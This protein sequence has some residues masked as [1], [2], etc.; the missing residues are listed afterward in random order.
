[1][2]NVGWILFIFGTVCLFVGATVFPAYGFKGWEYATMFII[3]LG[4]VLY[5]AVGLC[6]REENETRHRVR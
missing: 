5:A 1:M 4:F 6:D 2:I 3:T